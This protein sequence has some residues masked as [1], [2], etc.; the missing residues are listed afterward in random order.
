MPVR[1]SE[2]SPKGELPK[3][4]EVQNPELASEP[5]VVKQPLAYD[6][7]LASPKGGYPRKGGLPKREI[8]EAQREHLN[9]IRTLALEKKR[10]MKEVTLKSKLAKS[11]PK[12]D[13]ARQYDDYVTQKAQQQPGGNPHKGGLPKK[14]VKRFVQRFDNSESETDVTESEEEEVIIKKKTTKPVKKIK[15]KIVY[16]SES[17]SEEEQIVVRK[18]STHK[19]EKL[20]KLVYK[21]TQEQLYQR[22][23]EERVKNSLMGYSNALGV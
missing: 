10:Q 17:E 14:Q 20:E 22:M 11:V 7:K 15:K 16:E 13:L 8:S 23:I 5:P 21:N 9:K 3:K 12:E 19:P 2:N 6:A 4:I 1:K 18:K